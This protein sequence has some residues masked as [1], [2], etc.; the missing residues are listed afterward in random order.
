MILSY[1]RLK[2]R[3]ITEEVWI[4][5]VYFDCAIVKLFGTGVV[6]SDVR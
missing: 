1:A 4:L 5:R 3:I 2:E 6:L